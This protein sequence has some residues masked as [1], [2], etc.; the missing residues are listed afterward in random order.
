[1]V[2]WRLCFLLFSFLLFIQQVF[3]RNVV[4]FLIFTF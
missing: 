3:N 1:L 4:D 2:N